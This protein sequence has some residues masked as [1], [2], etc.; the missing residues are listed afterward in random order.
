MYSAGITKISGF[1]HQHNQPSDKRTH[2]VGS[3]ST[4]NADFPVALRYPG[5]QIYVHDERQWYFLDCQLYAEIP[6][7]EWKPLGAQSN[8]GIT[9]VAFGGAEALEGSAKLTYVN[10]VLTGDDFSFKKGLIY[11]DDELVPASL[12][13]RNDGN[14]DIVIDK[15]GPHLRIAGDGR[16][17]FY[18]QGGFRTERNDG[19]GAT[20]AYSSGYNGWVLYHGLSQPYSP[21]N[22]A[23]Q[24]TVTAN[25]P[26]GG[27]SFRDTTSGDNGWPQSNLGLAFTVKGSNNGKM[28]QL[29]HV[30]SSSNWYLRSITSD[31]GSG[32]PWVQIIHTGNIANYI[33]GGS[34]ISEWDAA[35]AY[36]SGYVSYDQNI[37]KFV[38]AAPNTGTVPGTDPLIWELS[39]VGD[40]VAANV[41]VEWVNIQ[42]KPVF[43]SASL[44]DA[45][46]FATAAQGT[47]ADT[48]FSWGNHASVGYLTSFSETDPTV[49]AHVK[50]ITSIQITN[51]DA[52][53]GWGNHASAGY[54]TGV[55][56]SIITN[57]P[58]FATVAT[59]GSYNDLLNLPT[60]FDGAYSSLSGIPTTFAPSAHAHVL[61]DL[62]QGD[63]TTGQA[64]VWNGT[65]WA[66]GTVGSK[67]T[68]AP[69]GNIRRNSKIGIGV[70]P[71][72]MIQVGGNPYT[73]GGN[74]LR[75][76]NLILTD[77]NSYASA[78][79][80]SGIHNNTLAFVG[81][82][83]FGINTS[84]TP[85][86]YFGNI[87]DFSIQK[88]SLTQHVIRAYRTIEFATAE[89][90]STPLILG[91]ISSS[92]AKVQMPQLPIT[93]PLIAGVLWNDG[94]VTKISGSSG[95]P[96]D[97]LYHKDSPG[98]IE[99]NVWNLTQAEF[100]LIATKVSGRIYLIDE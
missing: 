46:A 41:N 35:T 82:D 5:C 10:D 9:K 11:S 21:W 32:T 63:A 94:G 25:M 68:D 38:G 67:W 90:A 79:M 1:N 30:K 48:A 61:S 80:I 37:Y 17:F 76:G 84:S 47:A 97:L 89:Q 2:V 45:S 14:A 96:S 57:K 83:N 100:D 19:N 88:V 99:G 98:T 49:P 52:A 77:L 59:S 43:G 72:S 31:W 16:N 42:N 75:L 73:L 15:S 33:A 8:V 22:H 86:I 60:L 24:Y 39:S 3:L 29:Y 20:L 71:T 93:D 74:S 78:S 81:S 26:T 54:L 91:Y 18:S 13:F 7:A 51:W 64:V 4:V 70:D 34:G 23:D 28:W 12:T 65:A 44:E 36:S 69:D 55:D 62:D 50:A 66:P 27:I 95:T 85:H 6:A 53:F 87:N 40:Y 58:A 56:W 92:V